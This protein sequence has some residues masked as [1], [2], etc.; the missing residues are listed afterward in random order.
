MRALHT[1]AIIFCVSSSGLHA[2]NV[3]Y[4][5]PSGTVIQFQGAPGLAPFA[6]TLNRGGG[7]G[8]ITVTHLTGE[9]CIVTAS[10]A[11]TAASD[12]LVSVTTQAATALDVVF[13]VRVI[14]D[15]RGPSETAQ[16]TGNWRAT[17]ATD[18]AIPD[19]ECNGSG[20][21]SAAVTVNGIRIIP[22]LVTFANTPFGG[23]ISHPTR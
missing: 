20:P 1:A 5:S 13:T 9:H 18:N 6:M 10:A 4:Q 14:R 3:V 22:P 2:H 15:P 17:G 23:T 8:T 11:P 7:D 16:L 21:I 12:P 19:P